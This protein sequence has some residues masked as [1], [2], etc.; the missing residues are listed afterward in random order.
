MSLTSILKKEKGR[1]NLKSWFQ[2]H[3]PNPGLK[4][5]P[6]IIVPPFNTNSSY[7]GEIGTAFDYLIRFNLERINKKTIISKDS[8]VAES[9]LESILLN[10]EI[11]KEKYISIGYYRDRPVNRIKFKKF[12]E[13][14]FDKA[15][16]NH[17]EFIKNGKMTKDLIKSSLFL[18]KL[19]VKYRAGITD[20]NLDNIEPEKIVELKK[21]IDIVPWNDFKSEN[22]CFLPPLLATVLFLLMVQTQI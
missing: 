9:G 1:I 22:H 6:E 3:F 13:T 19:D 17:K 18:A 12:L 4:D 14:E 21:L 20:S 11:S 10:F 2:Y 7:V 5:S 8:W 16:K 15:K